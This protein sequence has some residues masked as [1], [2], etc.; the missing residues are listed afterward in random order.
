MWGSLGVRVRPDPVAHC[1]YPE[2]RAT[3]PVSRAS[4]EPQ[5]D[6]VPEPPSSGGDGGDPRAE[7]SGWTAGGAEEGG[8]DA[9]GQGLAD[10]LAVPGDAGDA[11]GP[12][13]A[14]THGSGGCGGRRPGALDVG[15]EDAAEGSEGVGGLT[16]GGRP[17]DGC[18][19]LTGSSSD[20]GS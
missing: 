3:V 19:T 4:A 13:G 11:G 7:D 1:S 6:V 2:S 14:D 17:K 20:A 5:E 12:V 9:G 18:R 10:G 8:L 16:D 15:S